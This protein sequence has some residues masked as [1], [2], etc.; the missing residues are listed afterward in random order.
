MLIALLK[1]VKIKQSVTKYLNTELI[2]LMVHQSHNLFRKSN[3]FIDLPT[4]DEGMFEVPECFS[5]SSSEVE[6]SILSS[7]PSVS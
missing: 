5:I 7:V 4:D 3:I 2:E 6:K 1:C